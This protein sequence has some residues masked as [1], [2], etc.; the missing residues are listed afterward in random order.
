MHITAT[1]QI[2]LSSLQRFRN[3]NET[4][5]KGFYRE[6]GSAWGPTTSGRAW[7]ATT[8]GRAW[9]ATTTGSAWQATTTGS[10]W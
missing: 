3:E 2:Q 10:A 5:G 1:S 6:E 9:Q 4:K 8:S 7:Q